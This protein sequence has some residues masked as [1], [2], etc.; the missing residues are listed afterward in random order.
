MTL[1]LRRLRLL[2][3]AM[4]GA[5]TFLFDSVLLAFLRPGRLPDPKERPQCLL[6]RLD[7]IGDVVLWLPAARLVADDRRRKGLSVIAVVADD[8]AG[9]ARASA[10]FDDVFAIDRLRFR[11]DPLYRLRQLRKVGR[12]PA[13][14]AIHPVWSRALT[15]GDAVV[16]FTG[17]PDRIG[18]NGGRDNMTRLGRWLGNR[19][20]TRL[21]AGPSEPVP[22]TVRNE[23]FLKGLGLAG[24]PADVKRPLF[25]PSGL[26]GTGPSL[27]ERYIVVVP[28]ASFPGRRWPLARFADI[29]AAL[30]HATGLPAVICGTKPDGALARAILARLSAPARPSDLTGRTDL[31]DLIPVI[32]GA[33]L[34]LSNETAAIHMAAL[35]GTPAVCIAGGGFFGRFIPYGPSS[36]MQYRPPAVAVHRMPCFRCNWRCP[37]P[38]GEEGAMPCIA[39]VTVDEV[40]ALALEQLDRVPATGDGRRP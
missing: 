11:L 33:T 29:I 2:A 13:T 25:Y 10:L 35:L 34:L 26:P 3:I 31:A 17:A 18:W 23:D 8:V 9:L 37:F 6:I 15:L 16:R 5:V 14:E 24:L 30:H 40:L 39:A 36:L 38:P 28:G 20:Y 7:R 12:F 32:G 22:E 1:L 19:G 27:P 21:I 4:L